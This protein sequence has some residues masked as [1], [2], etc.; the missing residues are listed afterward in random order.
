[1]EKL[2]YKDEMF[3]IVHCANALD[4]CVDPFKA[5][6]EMYRVCK[7]GGWIYLRHAINSGKKERYSMQHQWN[8]QKKSD[9]CLFW[10]YQ[11]EFLLSDVIKGFNSVE[12]VELEGEPT[13]I[14]STLQK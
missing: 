9:D 7:P 6:K 12:K 1:M 11:Y 14:V 10:N 13:T 4:H 8:I 2:T 3:D 5:L